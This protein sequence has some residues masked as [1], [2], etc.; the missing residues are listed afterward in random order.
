MY[1]TRFISLGL[2][3]GSLSFANGAVGE[4]PIVSAS[5]SLVPASLVQIDE[6]LKAALR[7]ELNTAGSEHPLQPT[8]RLARLGYQ[9]INQEILDYTCVLV[10]RERVNGILGDPETIF[11]KVRHL[12]GQDQDQLSCMDLHAIRVSGDR[13]RARAAF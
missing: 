2:I 12:Q 11:A 1:N 4:E 10:R 13:S 3:A 8:L 9:R 5:R 6:D 7:R